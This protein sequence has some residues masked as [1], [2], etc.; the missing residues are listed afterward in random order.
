MTGY[1]I[2]QKINRNSGFAISKSRR[3]NT[4]CQLE[5][6]NYQPETFL[7]QRS[8]NQVS[9]PVLQKSFLWIPAP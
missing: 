6:T 9:H 5:I 3:N 4:G 2:L 8:G 7:T 1:E